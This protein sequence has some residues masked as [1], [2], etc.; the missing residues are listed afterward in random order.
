MCKKQVVVCRVDEQKY[1]PRVPESCLNSRGSERGRAVQ[2]EREIKE[3]ELQT[4]IAVE[5][6]QRQVRETKVQ[7]DIAIE[8][9]RGELVDQQVAN[10]GKEAK[11]RAEALRAIL[12]PV[13]DVDWKTLLATQGNIDSKQ[14]IAMAFRDLAD[15]ADKIGTLNISPELMN[16]LKTALFFQ[17][18]SKKISWNLIRERSPGFLCPRNRR[19]WFC[20]NVIA[21]IH[22]AKTVCL[23]RKFRH[24]P[25]FRFL[26]Q[27]VYLVLNWQD[28]RRGAG[29]GGCWNQGQV[30]LARVLEIH[31][32]L[33]KPALV[34]IRQFDLEYSVTLESPITGQPR[35][36]SHAERRSMCFLSFLCSSQLQS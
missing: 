30:A 17:M 13:K 16:S 26:P 10:E 6:K 15:N 2:L 21:S 19:T 28:D 25:E 35:I 31:H 36:R 1:S 20:L 11:A 29:Q 5:E 22:A 14:M 33:S 7:A 3:A 23:D 24:R 32:S 27:S 8:Q 9:Q 18:E 34:R 4:D 12:E